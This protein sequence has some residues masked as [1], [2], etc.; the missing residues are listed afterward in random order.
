MKKKLLL[1]SCC[2]PCSS[3]VIDQL[4]DEYD[5]TLYY[6]NPNIHPAEEY[7]LRLSEQQ[8]YAD[9]AGVKVLPA[10]YKPEE[11]FDATQGLQ[12]EPEGGKRCYECFKL[13]LL[14]TAE[15]ARK[16][17]FD[18][19]TSTMSVS[20]YKNFE[21]LNDIG[22]WAS[23]QTGVPYLWANFKKHDGYLHS[24]QNSKKFN[25]YRQ[26]YCGCVYSLNSTKKQD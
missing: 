5:V 7:Q 21:V 3:G 1:H 2:G 6:Y 18:V 13:R 12:D 11:Y 14:H 24:I 17:G 16:H 8:R 26:H 23:E 15:Y 22:K 25:L 20:P 4:T 9:I 10:E 19:F